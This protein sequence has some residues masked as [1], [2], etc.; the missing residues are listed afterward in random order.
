MGGQYISLICTVHVLNILKSRNKNIIVLKLTGI[1]K[2]NVEKYYN[3]LEKMI[4]KIQQLFKDRKNQKSKKGLKTIRSFKKDYFKVFLN[5][6]R[7][8][9]IL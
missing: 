8:K 4:T 5:P 6:K 9:K 3:E 7:V 1:K 2:N